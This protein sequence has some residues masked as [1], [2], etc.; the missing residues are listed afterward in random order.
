MNLNLGIQPWAF[1]K[2]NKLEVRRTSYSDICRCGGLTDPT[3]TPNSRSECRCGGMKNTDPDYKLLRRSNIKTPIPPNVGIVPSNTRGLILEA[4]PAKSPFV[5]QNSNF[6]SDVDY[7]K[8]ISRNGK[9][10]YPVVDKDHSRKVLTSGMAV[11]SKPTDIRPTIEEMFSIILNYKKNINSPDYNY[12]LGL[13]HQYKKL[14]SL[15]KI[16]KLTD[17]E[18]AIIENIRTLLM[19]ELEKTTTTT[20]TNSTSYNNILNALN[21]I[22]IGGG[23]IYSAFK[24][25]EI[26]SS[27]SSAELGNI[28][29][30][31]ENIALETLDNVD[32]LAETIIK[33]KSPDAYKALVL[34]KPSDPPAQSPSDFIAPTDPLAIG[35]PAQSPVNVLSELTNSLSSV[36]KTIAEVGLQEPVKDILKTIG[37]ADFQSIKTTLGLPDSLSRKNLYNSII[38][39]DLTDIYRGLSNIATTNPVSLAGV[40]GLITE[41]VK[42]GGLSKTPEIA[43]N[44]QNVIGLLPA[45]ELLKVIQVVGLP[46]ASSASSIMPLLSTLGQSALW[47]LAISLIMSSLYKEKTPAQIK[48]EFDQIK[49]GFG[50]RLMPLDYDPSKPNVMTDI[51]LNPYRPGMS[52]QDVGFQS[53][54]VTPWANQGADTVYMTQP[55]LSTID[56]KPIL[57]NLNEWVSYNEIDNLYKW[58]IPNKKLK[59]IL[60]L[61]GENNTSDVR[62][63]NINKIV[64]TILKL[65]KGTNEYKIKA[66]NLETALLN[67]NINR[68]TTSL[69]IKKIMDNIPE[70]QYEEESESTSIPPTISSPLVMVS[71]RKVFADLDTW[72]NYQKENKKRAYDLSRE[73]LTKILN[74]LGLAISYRD[75]VVI[76]NKIIE[77]INT[78]INSS[79]EELSKN[80][81]AIKSVILSGS[82][83]RETT[84]EQIDTIIQEAV[85][86][87]VP[88]VSSDEDEPE[89]QK[90][91][92][93]SGENNKTYSLRLLD[94][95]ILDKGLSP[96]QKVLKAL[97]T[98]LNIIKPSPLTVGS[99]LKILKKY[100][101]DSL[102]TDPHKIKQRNQLIQLIADN[103]FQNS[104]TINGLNSIDNKR[105]MSSTHGTLRY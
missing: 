46:A 68:T 26:L 2:P 14:I 56:A 31:L 73:K 27:L 74:I 6:K 44:L 84:L 62:I 60:K 24:V 75:R 79:D 55:D 82:I 80:A 96:T 64:S 77:L 105:G 8:I 29:S 4:P 10:F 33:L 57:K 40:A 87:E 61:L 16:R 50:D 97:F 59:I 38:N 83:N 66:T 37:D 85:I 88:P 25:K 23:L 49:Q 91:G 70:I 19:K 21:S 103:G 35:A 92:E 45:P 32:K 43:A 13:E 11:D 54:D 67:N 30:V 15:S 53:G 69:N 52:A 9:A 28:R 7:A 41:A 81:N 36:G 100:L 42:R 95:L 102:L 94:E 18:N 99:M 58:Q 20:P 71:F 17:S 48:Q 101:N 51:D 72:G 65:K 89:E 90:E 3:G 22:A 76:I 98:K 1:E 12:W 5:I 63:D 86:N 47:G 93:I 104:T 39:I 34:L 78:N